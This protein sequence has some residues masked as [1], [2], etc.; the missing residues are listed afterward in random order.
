MP[1]KAASEATATTWPESRATIFGSAAA[2]VTQVA[3]A[4]SSRMRRTTVQSILRAGVGRPVPALA[5]TRSKSSACTALTSASVSW[6][7][8]GTG[9][10]PAA[11]QTRKYDQLHI[12]F[13]APNR[14]AVHAF[15]EAAIKAGAKDNGGPG[16][17]ADY[18]PNYY[19]AF[20]LDPDGHNVEAC[21]HEPE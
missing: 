10:R 12:A 6:T 4:F 8:S 11:A 16:T 7:S 13:R 15:H 5:M 3:V 20:V 17:R 18:H 9:T 2:M 1:R 21:C 19:G 14:K